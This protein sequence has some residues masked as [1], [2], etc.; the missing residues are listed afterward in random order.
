MCNSG[1]R[2]PVLLASV[3]TVCIWYIVTNAGKTSMHIRLLKQGLRKGKEGSHILND[4]HLD[5]LVTLQVHKLT[6]T[7]GEMVQE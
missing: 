5:P 6:H 4:N 1:P 7:T 3:D 2:D